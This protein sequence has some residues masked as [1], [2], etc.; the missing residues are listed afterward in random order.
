MVSTSYQLLYLVAPISINRQ[1]TRPPIEGD[2]WVINKSW[3]FIKYLLPIIDNNTVMSWSKHKY[4]RWM[5]RWIGILVYLIY[6]KIVGRHSE[7]CARV[8]VTPTYVWRVNN[9]SDRP[10]Y[11]A[12]WKIHFT[13]WNYSDVI[14]FMENLQS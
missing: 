6:F 10:R 8:N 12:L 2:G 9:A 7:L 1:R 4:H 5:S 14:V 11:L 3:V 13:W